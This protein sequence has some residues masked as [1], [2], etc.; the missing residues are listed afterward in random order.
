MSIL[1]K[2]LTKLNPE[3]LNMDGEEEAMEQKTS[4]PGNEH[5]KAKLADTLTDEDGNDD[6]EIDTIGL[7]HDDFFREDRGRA[8]VIHG[9]A[10][11]EEELGGES[12]IVQVTTN[13]ACQLIDVEASVDGVEESESFYRTG[14]KPALQQIEEEALEVDNN[15]SQGKDFAVP[16]PVHS[17]VAFSHY[18]GR[19]NSSVTKTDSDDKLNNSYLTNQSTANQPM[20]SN[21]QENSPAAE[22]HTNQHSKSTSNVMVTMSKQSAPSKFCLMGVVFENAKMTKD[23]S[24][25][26]SSLY[27]P[28]YA[29]AKYT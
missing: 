6:T 8:R 15:E 7:N 24:A 22:V 5:L 21:N 2:V 4:N 20:G 1:S 16:S 26:K 11:F 29:R 25:R 14:D 28:S 23:P 17:S 9:D 12:Q 27:I 3:E 13:L 19:N 10:E 18:Y